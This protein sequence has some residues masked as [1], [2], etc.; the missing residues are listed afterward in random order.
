[1]DFRNLKRFIL[2]FFDYNLNAQEITDSFHIKHISKVAL[3]RNAAVDKS[4]LNPP[5][6]N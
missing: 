2:S 6:G 4:K 5:K 3:V 1:M